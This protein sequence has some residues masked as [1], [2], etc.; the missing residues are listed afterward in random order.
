MRITPLPIYGV[1]KIELKSMEDSRGS[2]T[3]QFCIKEFSKFGIGFEIKQCNLSQNNKTGTVRGMHYQL[4]P[5]PEIKLV[6][7]L[8]GKIHDVV[9]DLRLNS[10]TYL[11]S[12]TTELSE[13]NNTMLYI[14]PMV[15][16]GFQTLTDN[17]TV[18]Y[19]LSEFFMPEYYTGVRWDDPSIKIK[20]PLEV[21]D[22]S[23]KDAKYAFLYR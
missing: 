10:P 21:T 11:H 9:V 13:Y 8:R 23:E 7:C 12:I 14:P 18:Y 20:W 1:Y 3:R 15:A 4:E 2:F 22:I 16:H 6:S 17:A 19:Q 5:Y